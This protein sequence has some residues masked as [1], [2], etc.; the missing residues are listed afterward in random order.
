MIRPFTPADIPAMMVLGS[1][2]HAESLY[3]PLNYSGVRLHEVAENMI[4]N[5]D[6]WS[7]VDERDGEIVG[8]II[9]FMH[10]P[11][12]SEDQVA[13]D[14]LLYVKKECRGSTT[15]LRL[16]KL[17]VDWARQK[18]ATWCMLGISTGVGI[19]RTGA[20]YNRM[21]FKSHGPM[22]VKDLS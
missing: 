17:Y 4:T 3:A 15:A 8:M 14:L 11:F 13:M 7:V 1:Q 22:F 2:M 10:K 6:W 21:G 18:G 9:A 19:E 16:I 12:F 5:D 20:F